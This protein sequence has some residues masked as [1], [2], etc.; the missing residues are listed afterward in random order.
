MKD[1]GSIL[2]NAVVCRVTVPLRPP[3]CVS[4]AK[5]LV[6]GVAAETGGEVVAHGGVSLGVGVAFA[7]G[8][9]DLDE[10]PAGP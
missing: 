8:E 3:L 4:I 2:H 1:A 7:A 5:C 10:G 6:V 9:V